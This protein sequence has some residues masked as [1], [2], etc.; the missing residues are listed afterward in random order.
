MI[1]SSFLIYQ[2]NLHP[3][4]HTKHLLHLLPLSPDERDDFTRY[5]EDLC[6]VAETLQ[7]TMHVEYLQRLSDHLSALLSS[8]TTPPWQ[9]SPTY[10]KTR[11]LKCGAMCS[12]I[13]LPTWALWSA[14]QLLRHSI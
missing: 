13:T 11:V 14:L 6:D 2:N 5:R 9:V 10:D 12:T 7:R 8:S 3:V 1:L 4:R